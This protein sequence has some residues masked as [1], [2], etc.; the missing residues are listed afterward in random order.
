MRWLLFILLLLAATPAAAQFQGYW[1]PQTVGPITCIDAASAPVASSVI[2]NLGQSVHYLTWTTSGTLNELNLQ[3]EASLDNITWF[4][5]S[6]TGTTRTSGAIWANVYYP[7]I[8]C[9]LTA[10]SGGGTV[11]GVYTGTSVTAGPPAGI[12]NASGIFTK[13]LAIGGIA[14]NSDEFQIPTPTGSTGGT[15][16]IDAS[17]FFGFGTGNR[18]YVWPGVAQID[19]RSIQ[20]LS[21]FVIG[22]HDDLQSFMVPAVDS[23]EVL[24]SFES[25]GTEGPN[26]TY[27]LYYSFSPQGTTRASISLPPDG[28]SAFHCNMQAAISL[29]AAGNTEIIPA[30]SG[31]GPAAIVRTTRICHISI[32]FEAMVDVSIRSGG[33]T[34][35]ASGGAILTGTYQDVLSIALDFGPEGALETL[36]SNVEQAVCVN[37]GAA[38]TGGGVVTYAILPFVTSFS[39]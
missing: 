14:D 2:S 31:A 27:D 15:L 26:T 32:S 10:A 13:V 29:S 30:P 34:N 21:E 6:E 25:S 19:N 4:R 18:L 3:L 22:A 38:V 35:C 9:N 39:P 12:F 5:I 11:T 23:S 20:P 17:D 24:I 28:E 37:L 33:G 36:A 8:R 7:F 16:F 1:S